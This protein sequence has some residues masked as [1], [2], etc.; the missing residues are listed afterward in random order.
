M[1]GVATPTWLSRPSGIGV[2][3]SH[4]QQFPI[5][6]SGNRHRDAIVGKRPSIQFKRL[7]LKI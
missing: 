3:L 2:F 6:H 7:I 4:M 1:D 5:A